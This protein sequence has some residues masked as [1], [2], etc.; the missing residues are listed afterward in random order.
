[1]ENMV[2]RPAVSEDAEFIRRAARRFT[3]SGLPEWRN[4]EKALEFHRLETEAVLAAVAAG[5]TVLIAEEDSVS[6]GFI[7]LKAEE[8]FLTGEAQG[9]ISDVA[10]A[11]EAEGRGVGRVLM[12]AAEDWARGCGY[13][14]LALD[15][16]AANQRARLFYARHGFVEQT[17]KMIKVVGKE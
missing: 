16:F 10:V 9:Y 6:L 1:M 14:I 8:D 17:L 7:Y 12:Q 3:E 5:E 13:R 11:A 15:V 2:V 4:Q